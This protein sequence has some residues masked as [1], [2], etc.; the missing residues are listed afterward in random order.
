MKTILSLLELTSAAVTDAT[1]TS[2]P[3]L[4]SEGQFVAPEQ[5]VENVASWWDK[6]DLVE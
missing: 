1:T 2:N 5:A 6:L 3:L 4:D